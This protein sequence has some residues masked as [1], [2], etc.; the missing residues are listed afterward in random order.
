M[1]KAEVILDSL[2]PSRSSRLTTLRVTFPRY[3]LP[4]FNTHRAF[5]RNSASTRA[6][7]LKKFRQTVLDNPAE[8]AF[9]GLVGKGMQAHGPMP[10]AKANWARRLWRGLRYPACAVHWVLEKLGASKE[11][12]SRLL[13]PWAHSVVLVTATD[14]GWS[15]FLTLRNHPAADPTLQAVAQAVAKSIAESHPILLNI[16][17]WHLPF[18]NPQTDVRGWLKTAQ[19]Q[20]VARCARVSYATPDQP[21]RESQMVE[22]AALYQ[23]LVG[24][25]PKHCSPAEHQAC[26]VP[27]FA[28]GQG[29][30]GPDSGWG[31]FRK[32][33]D[34]ESQGNM[35]RGPDGYIIGYGPGE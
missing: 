22:D 9:W 18:S 11:T 23:R 26:A 10:L 29:N 7:P 1:I 34:G 8:P 24:S 15:N 35:F 6:I 21:H 5:S 17:G 31:Q 27:M 28:T 13:E 32:M 30:F 14:A 4:E 3:L 2:H 25:D 16:G 20:S 33:L 12:A 19:I